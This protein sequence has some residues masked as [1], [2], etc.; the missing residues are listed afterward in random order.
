MIEYLDPDCKG[1]AAGRV[2]L[3]GFGRARSGDDDH[4]A[5]HVG[6]LVLEAIIRERSGCRH[7]EGRAH[8][9]GG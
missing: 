7:G 1:Y 2:W 5:G 4:D 3:I 8:S 6:A 9:R